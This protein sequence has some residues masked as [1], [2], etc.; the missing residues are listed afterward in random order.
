MT[1]KK[2][3]EITLIEYEELLKDRAMLEA[4]MAAGVNNWEGWDQAVS[5]YN[6]NP[7][8]LDEE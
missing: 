7:D 8:S 4:L 6:K 1:Y 2:I 5:E 3:I